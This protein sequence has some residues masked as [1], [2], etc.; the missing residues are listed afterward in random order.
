MKRLVLEV[1]LL[2]A[3]AA[4]GPYAWYL[5]TKVGADTAKVQTMTERGEEA[6]KKLEEVSQALEAAQKEL[7]PL[8]LQAQQMQAVRAGLANRVTIKDLEAAYAKEKTLT[9]ER[10]LGVG[11]LRLLSTGQA[12]EATLQS[13]KKA[14]DAADWGSRKQVICAAQNALAFAG[15][16]VQVLDECRPELPK[17]LATQ[18]AEKK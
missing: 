17:P 15:Q 7:E 18:A 14:L 10:H 12:D 8:R 5:H 4:V 6:T 11:V 9:P 2:I 3:L 16:K 13:I 1:F